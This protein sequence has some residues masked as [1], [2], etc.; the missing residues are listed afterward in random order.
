[1]L[2]EL[3]HGQVEEVLHNEL[4]GRIGCHVDGRTYVVPITYV[5]DGESIYGHSSEGQKIRMM[6]ENPSVCFE[7]DHLDDLH[8]WR[9]VIAQGRYEEL[10]GP[11]AER[12]MGLLL[13]RV[14]P[15]MTS[16]TSRPAQRPH[17]TGLG[18]AVIYRIALRE[19][20]GRFEQ[21]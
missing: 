15:L 1:M 16:E 4:I 3:S 8:T 20:T 2:G 17:G 19:K 13:A 14:M 7:V 11:E 10:H 9:G 12:A 6:R 18:S 21:G 5:Y